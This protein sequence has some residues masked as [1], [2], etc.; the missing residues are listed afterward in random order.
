MLDSGETMPPASW[1]RS[2]SRDGSVASLRDRVGVDAL[3]VEHRAA[4]GDRA[5]R[6]DRVEE[7]LGHEHLVAAAHGQGA[8][9]R[10]QLAELRRCPLPARRSWPAGS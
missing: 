6:P 4:N 9:P 5:E 1:P 7:R 10:E 8:R 3:A 2:T